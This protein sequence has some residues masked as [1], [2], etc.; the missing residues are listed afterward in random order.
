MTTD[1]FIIVM[2]ILTT[3]VHIITLYILYKRIKGMYET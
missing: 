3:V 1:G 2:F